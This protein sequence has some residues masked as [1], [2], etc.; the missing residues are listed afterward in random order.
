MGFSVGGGKT[1]TRTNPAGGVWSFAGLPIAAADLAG[2]LDDEAASAGDAVRIDAQNT[3][4]IV[5]NAEA[6]S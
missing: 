1:A 3:G 6:R 2:H 5:L 4:D